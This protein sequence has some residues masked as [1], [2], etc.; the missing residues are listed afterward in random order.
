V[1]VKDMVMCNVTPCI[2]VHRYQRFQAIVT[3]ILKLEF[4]ALSQGDSSKLCLQLYQ[5]VSYSTTDTITYT[6]MFVYY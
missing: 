2:L 3:F 1:S 5:T 4:R 6:S